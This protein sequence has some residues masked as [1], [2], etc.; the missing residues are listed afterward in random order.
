MEPIHPHELIDVC[1]LASRLRILRDD[2][3]VCGVLHHIRRGLP[4]VAELGR[5]QPRVRAHGDPDRVDALLP[6]V[7]PHPFRD[8]D[9]DHDRQHMRERACQLEEDDD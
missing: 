3:Q 8:H 7:V 2:D 5:R 9:G 1:K 4:A 6:E